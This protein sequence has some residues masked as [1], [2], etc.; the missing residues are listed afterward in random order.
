MT[1]KSPLLPYL[2]LLLLLLLLYRLEGVVV[3]VLLSFVG[4]EKTCVNGLFALEKCHEQL[5]HNLTKRVKR[6][7]VLVFLRVL[8]LFVFAFALGL[9]V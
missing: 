3:C 9:C 1:L 5:E 7:F 8:R 6:F 4:S 2:L